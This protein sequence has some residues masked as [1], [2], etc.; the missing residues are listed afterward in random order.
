M[1]IVIGLVI[2]MI[3]ATTLI[4]LSKK[5]KVLVTAL[6]IIGVAVFL[7]YGFLMFQNNA[8]DSISGNVGII[9]NGKLVLVVI[10]RWLAVV[11]VLVSAV[12][13]WFK[14]KA[15]KNI[16]ALIMPI[17]VILNWIF[18]DLNMIATI[19]TNKYVLF[20]PRVII[21]VMQFAF[22]GA[23]AVYYLYEKIKNKDFKEMGKQIKTL[24]MLLPAIM[25][26]VLPLYFFSV[27]FGNSGKE[28]VDFTPQ[29]RVMIYIACLAPLIITGVFKNKDYDVRKS[30]VVILS[31]A[32]FVQY[33]YT[34]TFQSF[35]SPTGLPFHLCNTA[36]LLMVMAYVFNMKGVFYFT[37]FV[38]VVGA[39]FAILLPNTGSSDLFSIGLI[40]FWYN[41]WYAFF[42][43]LLGITLKIYK[44]PN[45]KMIRGAIGVYTIYLALMI[46]LNSWLSNY[47][48]NVDYFFINKNFIVDKIEF[49]RPIKEK[50]VLFFTMNGLSFKIYWLY[51]IFVYVGYI[52][53]I[54]ITWAIYAYTYKVA[55]HY[56]EAAILLKEDILGI[57]ALKKEMGKR[58]ITEPMDNSGIDMIRIKHF[59]KRYGRGDKFAVKDF[60]LEVHAGEVFGF[61]GHN[62]AGKSTT[63]KSL[64]GIQSITEGSMEV[65][66]YDIS[67]QPLEAK[68]KIG[69]VSDNHAVYEHLTGREYI[70]YIADLYEVSANDRNE[71]ILKY[72][73]MFKLTG[74]LDREIK[75]Y[76][77]GMKQKVMVISALI[78]N[79]KV[80]ILDEPLTGLDPTS[81]YQIKEC[82]KNHA[83]E[84][85]IV[86]FSS[87]VIEV[88][89]KVCDKIAII[90]KGELKG[91][92]E[93]SDLKTQGINLE[94]LY[95]SFAD[96]E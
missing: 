34:Y 73:E 26:S 20:N 55:D 15:L 86:F 88:V 18:F 42:L 92:Y 68:K 54:L 91:V 80:W 53:F 83:K 4:I 48:P 35:L 49:L 43:P 71:R 74:D 60:N 25:L 90:S 9:T 82:M 50:F 57:A 22:M 94:D 56:T 3:I 67:K 32:G 33:F 75:G 61:L 21:F 44:R 13:M 47:D 27:F 62:G 7:S 12:V 28:V 76:S 30:V 69:Y 84:G 14:V 87:H 59:S 46:V 24:V 93:L 37:Y 85:N 72:G 5:S 65:C 45:F 58:S 36:I 2:T 1:A 40:H 16:M 23:L 78:H 19:G 31:L 63:I 96:V 6:K 10:L 95:M 11:G 70:D 89:E 29:H 66:G 17:V 39:L 81:A 64:V 8:I 79:P 51:D 38:N 41:H 77:H 52:I